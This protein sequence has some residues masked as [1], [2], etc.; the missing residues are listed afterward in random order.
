MT[1]LARLKMLKSNAFLKE[2]EI[3]WDD[4]LKLLLIAATEMVCLFTG[5]ALAL[6]T[7]S[8]ELYTG[9]DTSRLWLQEY[10]VD[11]ISLIELWDGVSAYEEEDSDYYALID[12]R[13]LQY[14]ALGQETSA[15]WS[16]W[17][18]TYELGIR[19]TYSAGYSTTNWE[20][21]GIDVD[22]NVPRDLEYAVCTI[23]QL[24]WM[25]GKKGG[26]RRGVSTMSVGVE[27]LTVERYVNELPKD[28]MRIL[29]NYRRLS[30]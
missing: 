29:N 26:G 11:E 7:Y 27:G 10:P 1:S 4:E 6:T 28:T 22:F 8:E 21:L 15:T 24:M 5:R 13:Y 17:K 9:N 16:K 25:E 20:V 18:S 3:T 23:A 12:K 14:P 19:V 30:I 2:D